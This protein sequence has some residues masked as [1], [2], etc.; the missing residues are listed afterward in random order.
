MSRQAPLWPI[1]VARSLIG[2]LWLFSCVGSC[3]GFYA[4]RRPGLMDWL[5]LEVT[6]AAFPLYGRIVEQL[7][8]PNFTLFAWLIFLAE[9]AVGLSLLTGA[10][11]R[12][13]AFLGLGPRRQP[14][15]WPA[16]CARRMALELRDACNVA[17]AF[18]CHRRRPR[19]GCGWAETSKLTSGRIRSLRHSL[20]CSVAPIL[21]EEIDS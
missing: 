1:A 15:H 13:G 18:H 2:L 21:P 3:P 5:Q 9:L 7:V 17:W 19:L 14:W 11:T 4:L 6:H 8:L 16:G 20:L 12:I 10:F